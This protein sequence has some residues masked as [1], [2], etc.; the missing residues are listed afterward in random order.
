[1]TATTS[2]AWSRAHGVGPPLRSATEI[3]RLV[4]AVG[5]SIATQH[6]RTTAVDVRGCRY[7]R[8][9]G[10]H[11]GQ[12]VEITSNS[13]S[14]AAAPSA[15]SARSDRSSS[16]SERRAA[17]ARKIFRA[18][19]SRAA[20]SVASSPAISSHAAASVRSA[21]SRRV[22]CSWSCVRRSSF[23]VCRGSCEVQGG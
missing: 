12:Y 11:N 22:I 5:W 7:T 13:S 16:R 9:H 15:T 20:R 17:R 10:H 4:A 23:V 2:R 21:T 14:S 8:N 3:T 6:S 19:A 18:S 1:M